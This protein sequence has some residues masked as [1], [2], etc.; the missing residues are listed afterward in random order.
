MT[1]ADSVNEGIEFPGGPELRDPFGPA[2]AHRLFLMS[3]S[4]VEVATF[5]EFYKRREAVEACDPL[6][7]VPQH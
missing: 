6:R 5:V 3:L 2:S 1:T 7:F 4:L